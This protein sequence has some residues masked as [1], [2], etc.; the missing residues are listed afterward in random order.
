[1]HFNTF[2]LISSALSF[3]IWFLTFNTSLSVSVKNSNIILKAI[4]ADKADII[5]FGNC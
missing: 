5:I 4:V 1:M 2:V 3:V